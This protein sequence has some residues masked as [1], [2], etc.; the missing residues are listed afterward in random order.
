MVAALISPPSLG[1]KMILLEEALRVAVSSHPILYLFTPLAFAAWVAAFAYSWLTRKN[2][3]PSSGALFAMTTLSS[4]VGAAIII[5]SVLPE[6]PG[7]LYK[8]SILSYLA[9]TMICLA[10]ITLVT[11][12][13]ASA[14]ALKL[15]N[16]LWPGKGK[17]PASGWLLAWT[18]LSLL[19]GAFIMALSAWH[20]TP[21]WIK[22]GSILSG[23]GV[24]IVCLANII[25][26]LAQHRLLELKMK[27]ETLDAKKKG[28]KDRADTVARA[29]GLT[30]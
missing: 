12:R 18:V 30:P 6:T 9:A 14:K 28:D 26:C 16:P 11:F 27:A 3:L 5:L 15:K 19:L 17:V 23:V 4:V 10:V 2:Q 24:A 25:F 20:D 8:N 1:G 22:T 7:W 29:I 21:E 13:V